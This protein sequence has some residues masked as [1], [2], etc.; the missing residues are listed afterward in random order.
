MG[1]SELA[2][3]YLATVNSL[4]VYRESSVESLD[5]ADFLTNFV[6]DN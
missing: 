1:V 6:S 3:V 2:H 4:S 5:S